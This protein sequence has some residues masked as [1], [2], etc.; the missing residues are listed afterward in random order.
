[1]KRAVKASDIIKPGTRADMKP[2][3]ITSGGGEIGVERAFQLC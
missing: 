1:M 2:L 3:R